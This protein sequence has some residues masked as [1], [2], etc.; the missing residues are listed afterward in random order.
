MD[1][2]IVKLTINDP[3]ADEHALHDQLVPRL[4]RASGFLAAVPADV[5]REEIEVHEVAEHA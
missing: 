1:V 2:A 3:P 5:A 4:S